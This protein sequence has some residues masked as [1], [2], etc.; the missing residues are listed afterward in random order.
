MTAI[1]PLLQQ[2]LEGDLVRL[3]GMVRINYASGPK[4]LLDGAGEVLLGAEVFRGLEAGFGALA[5]LDQLEDGSGDDA[6][7]MTLELLPANDSAAVLMTDPS[8][9]GT[10]IELMIGAV[11]DETGDLIGAPYSVFFGEIDRTVHK[12]GK[13]NLSVEIECVGGMERLFFNDEG[14]RLSSAFHKQVW[15]GEQGMDFATNVTQAIYW[16]T[17]VPRSVGR[18]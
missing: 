6:P 15:P 11:A 3:A 7:A 14:I 5:G 4:R 1:D 18:G 17:N 13:G 12:S 9:Q 8:L 16:G 2:A 10:T